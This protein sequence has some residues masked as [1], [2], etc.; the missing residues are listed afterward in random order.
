MKPEL[1]LSVL[2]YSEKAETTV[3]RFLL[4]WSRIR[5][6]H[7]QESRYEVVFSPV[8]DVEQTLSSALILVRTWTFRGHMKALSAQGDR[9]C[10]L[11]YATSP[12]CCSIIP[13]S[14]KSLFQPIPHP[15]RLSPW[16][17]MHR[18]CFR[19]RIA[20]ITSRTRGYLINPHASEVDVLGSP[21]TV[22]QGKGKGFVEQLEV[23]GFLINPTGPR[24]FSSY[25]PTA[26]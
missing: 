20:R 23:F 21:T 3:P 2:H 24:F 18:I 26:F 22:Q 7:R 17:R 13:Q 5:G 11:A 16:H 15:K 6:P 12:S 19:A 8:H 4:A 10:V 14:R 1:W 25:W 9:F